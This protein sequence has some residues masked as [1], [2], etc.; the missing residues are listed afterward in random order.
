M[1]PESRLKHGSDLQWGLASSKIFFFLSVYFLSV[2]FLS[3]AHPATPVSRLKER[4]SKNGAG[5]GEAQESVLL[6]LPKQTPDAVTMLK[7]SSV[8]NFLTCGF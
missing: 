8:L 3:P 4:I 1:G 6:C 5:N 2:T 7:P